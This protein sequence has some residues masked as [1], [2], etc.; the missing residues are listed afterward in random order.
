MPASI[1]C[2]VRAIVQRVSRASVSVD[3]E[4]VG[5]CGAGLLLLVGV[6]RGD[7]A[8]HAAKLA[9]K[10]ATLRIFNDGDG[11][12]NLALDDLPPTAE[13]NVLAISQFTVYG[14][15]SKN[16]RPSFVES[17]PYERGMELFDH[18]VDCLKGEGLVVETGRFGEHM[19]V[20]LVNDGPVTLVVDVP[21]MAAG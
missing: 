1:L 15:V 2:P 9:A 11:K 18:F 10:V 13:P 7:V 4:V 8:G 17:A 12:M 21:A 20:E 3:G 19:E 5:R 16:R 14:D 6:H